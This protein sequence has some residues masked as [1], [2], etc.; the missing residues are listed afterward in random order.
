MRTV[1]LVSIDTME[2]PQNCTPVA[3]TVSVLGETV[4]LFKRGIYDEQDLGIRE[5]RDYVVYVLDR[6]G[7]NEQFEIPN[8]SVRF[9]SIDLLADRSIVITCARTNIGEA[10]ATIIHPGDGTRLDF[11]AGDAIAHL[12]CDTEN[13]IWV[14]YFDEGTFP[15]SLDYDL[16]PNIN[17]LVCFSC[18]GELVWKHEQT[19][20]DRIEDCYALNVF[21]Q[22]VYAYY[23]WDFKLLEVGSEF[24]KKRWQVPVSGARY[25]G[26]DP[27][28]NLVL[29]AGG[30][31]EASKFHYLCEIHEHNLEIIEKIVLQMP[32]PTMDLPHTVICRGPLMSFLSDNRRFDFDLRHLNDN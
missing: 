16:E 10:N 9:P 12:L 6:D 5:P 25:F 8:L 21:E 2:T 27:Y 28:T 18:T 19:L 29:L 7:R 20:D 13:R 32:D 17:G 14:S 23:Y 11:I 4:L 1:K 3:A 24:A 15:K 30:Y 22:S 26:I 31:R